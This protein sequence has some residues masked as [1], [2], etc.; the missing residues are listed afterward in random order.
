MLNVLPTFP[1]GVQRQKTPPVGKGVK[2]F[3][4]RSARN[5]RQLFPTPSL[6]QIPV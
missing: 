1:G 4:T 2:N 6:F 3:F 5:T